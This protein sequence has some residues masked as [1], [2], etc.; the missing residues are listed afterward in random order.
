MKK[1]FIITIL[2]SCISINLKAQVFP[3]SEDFEAM[4]SFSAP[5]GWTTSVAG[6]QVY[7]THGTSSSKGLIKQ[8][9]SFNL[10]YSTTSPLIGAVSANAQLKFDYRV[11]QTSL[12]PASPITFV[13]GDKIEVKIVNGGNVT[14]VLTIDQSNHITSG[15]F[16]TKTVN[17][18]AF[19]G[20]NIS[21]RI[22]VT[23]ASST[24][25]CF[26]D[27]DNISINS[28]TG[29][30]EN[31]ETLAPVLFPSTITGNQSLSIKGIEYGNYSISVLNVNG[32]LVTNNKQSINS[33]VTNIELNQ[34]LKAGLYL[35]KLES[36]KKS[37]TLKFKVQ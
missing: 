36:E 25:D 22:K 5:S 14:T 8:L 12:Y 27:F 16:A 10:T 6:F 1:A 32:S 29:I 15:N 11:C 24:F 23:K 18:S 31:I 13:A 9:T 34:E 28:A 30:A 19:A 4:S 3:Y 17:L 35:L 20:Q 7:P 33:V 21:L 37:Y 2:I 26:M